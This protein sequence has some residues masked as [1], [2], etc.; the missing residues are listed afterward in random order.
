MKFISSV[1]QDIS[2]AENFYH[3]YVYEINIY[4]AFVGV[5][6][7]TRFRRICLIANT[8][9]ARHLVGYQLIYDSSSWCILRG[10]IY[11]VPDGTNTFWE[12]LV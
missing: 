5:S 3:T 10:F 1:E 8:C 2:V 12:I 4:M 9:S 6:Y 11:G 7:T